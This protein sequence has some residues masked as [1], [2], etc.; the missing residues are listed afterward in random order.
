MHY[1]DDKLNRVTMYRLVM[2][3]LMGLLV[4]GVIFGYLGLIP[5]S[6]ISLVIS[7]IYI[8][9]ICWVTNTIFAKVFRAPTNIESVYIT[10]LILVFIITPLKSFTDPAYFSLAAWASILAMAT[11]YILAIRKKHIFNPAAIA[12][13]I[14][15]LA[16][17]QSA[18]WW[19]GTP[20][21]ALPV[22]LGGY[23]LTRKLLH[24]DLVLGFFFS[25]V[26]GS[27]FLH[28][29]QGITL[30][31]ITRI[32]LSSPLLFFAFIMLTEPLTTPPT[33]ILRTLYGVVV[34][35]LFSPA[36]HIGSIFSTPELA[37]VIGNVFSYVASPKDKLILKLTELKKIGNDTYDFIFTPE[38]PILY[39]P[40]QYM[41]WTFSHPKSDNRGNRRYFTLSSS[42]TEPTLRIG[43][44]FYPDM[45]SFKESLLLMGSSSKIVASQTAG[46]FTL[47]SDNKKKLVFIS[48]GIGVTPFRSMIK[49]L[50]DKKEKRDIIHFYSNRTLG[51]VVY[52]DVFDA[53]HEELGIQT[54]YTL[55]DILTLPPGWRSEKGFI[56]A[57]MI[58]R[59]APDFV[60]RT[61][62]LS[63]PHAMV[64]T[65]ESLLLNMGVKS[66]SIKKDFF[67]G[68]V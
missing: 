28:L 14:T 24:L 53:A 43:L 66:S 64:T 67:P 33:K 3:Y 59:H 18:S 6:P 44:K 60:D 41:E 31:Y 47:S 50:V 65:F 35:V 15:S 56:D 51:D 7:T 27:V 16:L 61:F 17:G 63:G 13:V 21:M 22:V 36:V 40:G 62:Y 55:T 68:F 46:D 37:L 19:I 11:K 58:K 12:V 29:N 20:W 54:I 10:A 52:T 26:A 9:F 48:G 8:T 32:F 45:S 2:Y 39:K 5:F 42:P 49:Y 57:E 4:F 25:A 1:I 23:L 38:K 34:G 30:I